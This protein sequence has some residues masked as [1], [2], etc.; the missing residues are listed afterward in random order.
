MDVSFWGVN[1]LAQVLQ[2][3]TLDV[4]TINQLPLYE[5]TLAT[6]LNEYEYLTSATHCSNIK[7][8]IIDSAECIENLVY[9]PPFFFDSEGNPASPQ[10][11]GVYNSTPQQFQFYGMTCTA[12]ISENVNAFD[13]VFQ[14]ITEGPLGCSGLVKPASSVPFTRSVQGN[15]FSITIEFPVP[16]NSI[17][18]RAGILNSNS[19][20]TSGDVYYV[21]TNGGTPT[22]SINQGCKVQVIDNRFGGGI[23]DD[24]QPSDNLSDGNDSGGE[25][26]VTAPADYTSMTIYGNAPTGGPLFLGCPDPSLNCNRIYSTLV[27]YD[28]NDNPGVCAPQN[29]FPDASDAQYKVL[30]AHNVVTGTLEPIVLPPGSAFTV[31]NSCVS[32]NYMVWTISVDNDQ[33][34]WVYKYT[35]LYYDTSASGVPENVSWDGVIYELDPNDLPDCSGNCRFQ[36]GVSTINDDTFVLNYRLAGQAGKRVFEAS[37]V[38]GSNIL[39]VSLKF[40]IPEPFNAGSE[41]VVTLNEDGTPSKYIGLRSNEPI[42]VSQFDYATGNFEGDT[43]LSGPGLVPDNYRTAGDMCVIG[44]FLY[45]TARRLDNNTTELWKVSFDTLEWSIAESDDSY[46]GGSSGSK[47]DCRISDG[48]NF[49]NT[50]TTTTTVPGETTTTTTTVTPGIRTIFTKF[51][52]FDN[53]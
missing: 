13:G 44:E 4:Y 31:P 28:C 38:P 32:E 34:E 45:I 16:V 18:I 10:N 24:G 11:G 49:S 39:A 41:S 30:Q 21:E 25:F 2:P 22:L 47:P 8:D 48:F 29:N 42:V 23:G 52:G 12:S 15:N 35:R 46:N 43:T 17:P 27:S 19:D 53:P 50:T 36:G 9:L 5:L 40:I 7:F 33:D 51:E 3:E 26:K 20:L 14:S 37:F 1:G 6:S